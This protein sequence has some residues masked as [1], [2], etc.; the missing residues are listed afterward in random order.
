MIGNPTPDMTFGANFGANY[1][2]FDLSVFVQGT[3]GNEI[4]N[5][6]RRHDLT[7]SNMPVSYLE[8][9][10]GPGTSNDLPRFTWNDSNG[11]WSK[12]SDLYVENGSYLR[13]KNVQFGYNI[14][15]R[16]LQRIS[17]SKVRLYLSAD[18]L[19]TLTGYSG[20]DPEIGSASPLSV[21]VDRGVY[22]QARSYRLGV[23]ITF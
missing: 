11:N 17:L 14:P 10:R 7:M 19:F 4:F 6:T 1:K 21:G 15:D 5:A 23:N 22:P 2:Q 16:V 3:L 12:I 9:W 8:R 13:V 20:F 18:N